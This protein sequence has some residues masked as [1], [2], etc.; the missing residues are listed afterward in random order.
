MTPPVPNDD[1]PFSLFTTLPVSDA[2]MLLTKFE[3]AGIRFELSPERSQL[4]GTDALIASQGGISFGRGERFQIFTRP[5][6]AEA[7]ER[8]WRGFCGLES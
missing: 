7:V 8:I 3:K 1:N 2:R 5:D 4:E 6:D